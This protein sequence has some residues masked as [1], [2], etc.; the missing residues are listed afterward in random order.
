MSRP[1][2]TTANRETAHKKKPHREVIATGP[3]EA[4]SSAKRLLPTPAIIVNEK[5]DEL[6]TGILCRLRKETDPWQTHIARP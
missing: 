1:D 2:P 6:A 3:V 5:C 4:K